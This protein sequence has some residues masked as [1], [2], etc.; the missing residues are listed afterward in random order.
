MV[1][2]ANKRLLFDLPLLVF[3]GFTKKQDEQA[4][5]SKNNDQD[6]IPIIT[7]AVVVRDE[8]APSHI[9]PPPSM[10]PNHISP[11]LQGNTMVNYYPKVQPVVR[12]TSPTPFYNMG[13]NPVG[14]QC[15]YCHRQTITV[16]QDLIGLG[17]L[18][19]VF[20]LA[21]FFWPICWLPFCIPSCQ[22]SHHFCG[23]NECRKKIGE[24]SVCA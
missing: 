6:E 19:A 2:Y 17:T 20:L 18:I 5:S 15:P 22:R 24:T 4:K 14:L 23:H 10:N 11:A 21:L 12:F 13:R 16:V 8:E 1:F 9:P 3:G 7:D